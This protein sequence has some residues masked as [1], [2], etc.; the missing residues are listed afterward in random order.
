MVEN[1]FTECVLKN[2]YQTN[3]PFACFPRFRG[4]K[5][6]MRAIFVKLLLVYGS[7]LFFNWYN[8]VVEMENL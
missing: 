2:I 6:W 7:N 1:Q 5:F 4:M 3:S 8:V